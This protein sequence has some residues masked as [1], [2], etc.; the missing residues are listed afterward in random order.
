M[1]FSPHIV[2]DEDLDELALPTCPPLYEALVLKHITGFMQAQQ[3]TIEEFHHYCKRLSA[4]T[5]NRPRSAA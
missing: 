4:A 3:I 5:A 1:T 2:L